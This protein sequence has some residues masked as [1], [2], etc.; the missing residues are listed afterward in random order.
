MARSGFAKVLSRAAIGPVNLSVVG[1]AVVGA[2]ALASW[3]IAALGG[4]AY[5]ALVASDVSSPAFRRRVLSGRDPVT[6]IPRADQVADAEVRAIVERLVEVH[7][8]LARVVRETPERV[9]RNVSAALRSLEELERHAGA[10]IARAEDLHR[11]LSSVKLVEARAESERLRE[12]AARTVDAEARREYEAAAAAAEER[13]RAL[14]DIAS[15]RER[16]LA[17]LS[18]V[19]ASLQGVPAKLVRLRALDAVAGDAL[20][21]DVVAELERMTIDLRSFEQTLESLVPAPEAT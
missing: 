1:A 15:A 4:A 5:A 2:V 12:R 6:P 9:R 13:C 16:V 11:Y 14:D 10:L 18:R 21:G 7:E 19:A 20:S 3:P 8:E 17:N